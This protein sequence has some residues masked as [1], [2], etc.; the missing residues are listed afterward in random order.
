ME[1]VTLM[2][3]AATILTIY[4]AYRAAEDDYQE[5]MKEIDRIIEEESAKK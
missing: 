5:G 3:I 2:L 4:A 1:G